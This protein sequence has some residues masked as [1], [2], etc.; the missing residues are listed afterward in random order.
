MYRYFALFFSPR[1]LPLWCLLLG[2]AESQSAEKPK[3]V[4]HSPPKAIVGSWGDQ[5]DGTYRNPVLEANYPDN[6]VIRVGDTFYMM[7]ST[8]H[9]VPGMTI[10]KSKDLVNW[11]FSGYVM[12]GPISISPAY[13]YDRLREYSYGTWAGSF[14][15]NGEHYFAYWC[16]GDSRKF[17]VSK[18]K[19]ITGPWSEPAE[20]KYADGESIHDTDPGVLWDFDLH[21]AF[22]SLNC[23]IYELSW[24][25]LRVLQKKNEGIVYTR[26]MRGESNKLYKEGE[27]YYAMNTHVRKNHG[28]PNRMQ[29]FHRAK[30]ITGPWEGKLVLEDGNGCDRSPGQGSLLK[31]DDGSWWFIHQLA[32]GE[33]TGRYNGRPQFLEPVTWKDGW[34][35][36][37]TDTDGDGIGEVVWQHRKPIPSQPLAAPASEDEFS[38]STLGLQWQWHHNPKPDRWSLS[39]RPG[40]LRLKSC[41]PIQDNRKLFLRVPNMISQRL[42]GRSNNV[43]VARCELNGMVTGQEAGMHISSGTYH[44][45]AV[46]K[47]VDGTFETVFRS[48]E[49][50][51]SDPKQ[52]PDG[53]VQKGAHLTANVIWFKAEI[54][55]GTASF[56]YS[57][58]GTQF[59]RLGPAAQL[60]FTGFTASRVGF[61]THHSEETGHV[62][63]DWFHYDYDGPKAPPEITKNGNHF[64]N[65]QP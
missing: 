58:D 30:S 27:Y 33:P 49:P 15:Y 45:I 28:K 9:Y 38:A 64:I 62:D 37:G 46:V 23:Q 6:D 29:A 50:T 39:E 7:S 60:R 2:A 3:P 43:M 20:L 21:K 16:C 47:Q 14:G 13:H 52:M 4:V 44:A 48:D 53:L 61:Y 22:I 11:E 32:W 35:L 57:T 17:Y 19:A 1:H 10:L 34:P 65:G 41:V 63:V 5:G 51:G 8:C 26:Q 54:H 56:F 55:E 36:I 42:M 40:F 31:M 25:G 18:A 12:P 59:V 24:N